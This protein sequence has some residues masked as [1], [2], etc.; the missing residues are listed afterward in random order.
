[1]SISDAYTQ[2]R[3]RTLEKLALSDEA[4]TASTA[5]ISPLASGLTA[6][7]GKGLQTSL[8]GMA[9]NL[10]GRKIFRGNNIGARALGSLGS[11]LGSKVGAGL[12]SPDPEEIADMQR[13]GEFSKWEFGT[14]GLRTAGT[15]ALIG[16]ALASGA[17]IPAAIASAGT[18]AARGLFSG[19][20]V[21]P[22][23]K[24]IMQSTM[25]KYKERKELREE[26][27]R[28]QKLE[29]PFAES[30]FRTIE[31]NPYLNKSIDFIDKK[32]I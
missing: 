6:K 11:V 32:V 10:L 4:V 25:R 7:D 17:G 29:P 18:G 24:N 13:R 1:M 9:G 28:I 26:G 3:L 2:G 20:V 5:I 22:M 21:S 16:G 27:K 8:A 31:K 12:V 19:F 15:S 23:I 30:T 14:R